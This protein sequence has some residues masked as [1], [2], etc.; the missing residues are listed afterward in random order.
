[1]TRRSP[2]SPEPGKARRV[3]VRR[4]HIPKLEDLYK[5]AYD[6]GMTVKEYVDYLN[7]MNMDRSKRRN[8]SSSYNTYKENQ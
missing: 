2:S 1:M 8:N 3:V 5:E 6:R 4:K 7:A